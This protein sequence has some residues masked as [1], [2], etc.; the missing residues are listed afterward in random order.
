MNRMWLYFVALISVISR[1][2]SF[3]THTLS[4]H[5]RFCTC[6]RSSNRHH[7]WFLRHAIVVEATVR[8]DWASLPWPWRTCQ[9]TT[10]SQRQTLFIVAS[11]EVPVVQ[12]VTRCSKFSVVYL[13][14][15]IVFGKIPLFDWQVVLWC[16]SRTA[17]A[18]WRGF[19]IVSS[20][21]TAST[22]ERCV[23]CRVYCDGC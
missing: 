6:V 16:R 21:Y 8:P 19:V 3:C 9:P 1:F 11:I 18:L 12:H 4:S 14:D 22:W 5:V 23:V 17:G 20:S 2:L 7:F 13:P 15:A 10:I